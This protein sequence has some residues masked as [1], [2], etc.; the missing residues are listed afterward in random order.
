MNYV[1]VW[2]PIKIGQFRDSL[3]DLSMLHSLVLFF[4]VQI[5]SNARFVI[6]T[7]PRLDFGPVHEIDLLE[8]LALGLGQEEKHN[9]DCC[10]TAGRK[11]VPVSEIDGT[12][13][14]GRE[15]G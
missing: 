1:T 10:R 4:F 12:S 8:R 13:D 5:L 9:D 2:S 7:L 6:P 14:E 3:H 15:E 11:H